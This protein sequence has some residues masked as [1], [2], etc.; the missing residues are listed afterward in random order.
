MDAQVILAAT[1]LIP[2]VMGVMNLATLCRTAPTIF[3]PQEHHATKTDLIE[4]I[5][6][7]STK[8]TDHTPIMVLDIGDISAGHSPAA[9]PTMTEA[10]VLEGTPHIPLPATAAVHAALWPIDTPITTHTMT[11][12]DIVTP[13]P[14]LTTSPTD[15]THTTLQTRAS[16]TP[17]TPT[18]QYINLSPEKQTMSKPHNLP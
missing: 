16:L 17:A 1:S 12:T 2:S 15:V 13:H 11:P 6:T 7:S 10:A 4:G 9:I 5:N 3:L 18:A 8:G 14:T